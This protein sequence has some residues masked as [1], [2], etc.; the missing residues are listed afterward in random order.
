MTTNEIFWYCYVGAIVG[1]GVLLVIAF[2]LWQV[3]L[4]IRTRNL[5]EQM[6]LEFDAKR[7]GW[8]EAEWLAFRLPWYARMRRADDPT[9]GDARGR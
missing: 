1:L 8:T 2:A 7:A 5:L 9:A 3:V 6:R 4:E